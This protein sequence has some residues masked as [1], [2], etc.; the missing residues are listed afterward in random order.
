MQRKEEIARSTVAHAR[1]PRRFSWP[2][3]ATLTDRMLEAMLYASAGP[4]QGGRRQPAGERIF[5]DYA[6]QTVELAD[7]HS[8]RSGRPRS[9]AATEPAVLLA[10]RIEPGD[11]RT[12]RRSQHKADAPPGCQ[13]P[14]SLPR[15]RQPGADSS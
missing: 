13:P 14:E 4:A 6:G 9:D 10:R 7:G 5:V 12:C 15:A 1:R 11:R 3:P 2:V 8:G